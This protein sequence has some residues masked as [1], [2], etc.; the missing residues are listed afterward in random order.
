MRAQSSDVGAPASPNCRVRAQGTL[1]VSVARD[2]NVPDI[3]LCVERHA[4]RP[5]IQRKL[6]RQPGSIYRSLPDNYLDEAAE[7]IRAGAACVVHLEVDAAVGGLAELASLQVDCNTLV[8]LL[9]L[10]RVQWR[11]QKGSAAAHIDPGRRPKNQIRSGGMNA[12]RENGKRNEQQEDKGTSR[13]A[14]PL[15]F[16][17][18]QC[19]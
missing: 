12:P 2:H 5:I 19:R 11:L 14:S 18:A 7:L 16:D 13:H 6:N 10:L 17:T 4:S 8:E 15:Q 3:Y 1:A 9:E